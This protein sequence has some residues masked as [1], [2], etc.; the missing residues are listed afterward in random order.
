MGY[1]NL[2]LLAS[3]SLLPRA[4]RIVVREANVLEATARALPSWMPARLLYR[5]FYPRAAAIVAPSRKVATEIVGALPATAPPITVIPNPVDISSLRRRA[6]PPQR[7]AGHGLR[8]VAAGRLTHQKGF[9]RLVAQLPDLPADA[10]L[11]IYGDGPERG[12]LEEA[13]NRLSV[14]DKIRFAGFTNVLPAAMAGADAFL[15]PSRW[16]GLPNV[17]LESLAVGTPVIASS[18]AAVEEIAEIAAPGAV[19]IADFDGG[20][21]SW[22]ADIRESEHGRAELRPSLLPPLYHSENVIGRWSK[23]LDG[24]TRSPMHPDR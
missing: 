18:G 23:L 20:C 16:E 14:N 22:T 4:T 11:T 17:V 7:E 12:A 24:I 21:A 10:L 6:T 19:T 8:L 15:L 13:V 1:L 9:D 5:Q 3:A 2:A